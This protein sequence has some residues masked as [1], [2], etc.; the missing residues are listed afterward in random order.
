MFQVYS[1]FI[2]SS[3]TELSMVGIYLFIICFI[4]KIKLLYLLAAF[5]SLIFEPSM[6]YNG[7]EEASMEQIMSSSEK[8][9]RFK[10]DLYQ[11]EE[12]RKKMHLTLP[13]LDHLGLLDDM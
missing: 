12:I 6:A 8:G 4:Y 7:K 5:A 3:E 9:M 2:S 11:S 10:D 13:F 1:R